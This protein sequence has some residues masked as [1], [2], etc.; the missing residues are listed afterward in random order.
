MVRYECVVSSVVTAAVLGAA[1]QGRLR[2]WLSG[3]ASDTGGPG[4][5]EI[6]GGTPA[7]QADATAVPLAGREGA[8]VHLGRRLQPRAVAVRAIANDNERFEVCVT[9]ERLSPETPVYLSFEGE[10]WEGRLG[11]RAADADAFFDLDRTAARRIAEA[12]SVPVRERAPL[13]T[14]LRYHWSWPE[15]AIAGRAPAPLR[16][17]LEHTG[18]EPVCLSWGRPSFGFE[19]TRDGVSVLKPPSIYTGPA[20]GRV[21]SPGDSFVLSADL[22]D[23]LDLGQPGRHEVVA[24]FEGFLERHPRPGAE[25]D[26]SAM[27]DVRLESRGV[28]LVREGEAGPYR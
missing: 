12:F 8:A 20:P 17:H 11:T 24:R 27:W 2:A 13:D 28:V 5:P 1:L 25:V 19:A 16:L 7:R 14:G 26:R 6:R 22:H 15:G 9:V 21:L 23:D 10:A 4:V 18:G 3:S